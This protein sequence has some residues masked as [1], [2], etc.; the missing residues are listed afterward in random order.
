MLSIDPAGQS[1]RD[2]YKLLIGSI[3]PRPIALVTTLSPVGVLNAAPFSYF[4]IVSSRP[5]MLS[6]SVQRRQG[7]PKDTA[8]HAMAAGEFVV[9]V[10]DTSYLEK[11]NQTAAN[12]PPEASEVELAGLTSVPSEVVAVPGLAEAR[13][14]MECVLEQSLALGVAGETPTTDLLLGR[15]VR[16]HIDAE[17]YHEG[18]IDIARLDPVS[19]LAGSDYARLGEVISLPRPD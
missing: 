7:E 11:M 16:F 19:R 1:D 9:H 14:R 8:R 10:T 3:V 6:V 4:N 12:L 13:I 5:P 15:I 2:N 18:R 17:L